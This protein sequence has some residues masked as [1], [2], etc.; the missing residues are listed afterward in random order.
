MKDE[1][2]EIRKATLLAYLEEP[3]NVH[4]GLRLVG[5]PLR[6]DN[7]VMLR[8]PAGKDPPLH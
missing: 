6:S 2:K 8:P 3:V 4:N 5:G 1:G 7:G